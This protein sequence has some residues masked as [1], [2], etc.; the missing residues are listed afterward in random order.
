MTELKT[1][2]CSWFPIQVLDQSGE[3]AVFAYAD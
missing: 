1:L 2:E 3:A